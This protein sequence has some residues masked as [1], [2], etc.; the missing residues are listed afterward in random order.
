MAKILVRTTGTVLG[1]RYGET[2]EVDNEN[3]E[4]ASA[5]AGRLMVRVNPD[6]SPYVD[7]DEGA[8]DEGGP[9]LDRLTDDE[10]ATAGGDLL[11]VHLRHAGL[12][13]KGR[14]D[15][16][17]ALLAEHYAAQDHAGPDVDEAVA[18]FLAEHGDHEEFTDERGEDGAGDLT[19]G[20][21]VE[22]LRIADGEVLTTTPPEA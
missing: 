11:D 15:E 1:Y 7:G 14:V 13:T 12:S 4:V 9:G 5:I 20:S 6:G 17:R 2:A 19:C 18:A 22:A 3:E 21:C 10:L 8:G 16:R